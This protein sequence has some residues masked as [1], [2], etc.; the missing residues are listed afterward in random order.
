MIVRRI[1]FLLSLM[2]GAVTSQWPE[3][4]Q[5]YRQRLG[6]AVDELTRVLADF[7]RDAASA[8]MD[9]PAAI[10][11]MKQD[12]QPFYQQRGRSI[13]E[14]DARAARLS[15]QLDAFGTAGSFGRLGVLA[16][17]FDPGIAQRAYESFEPAVP[18]T[19]EGGVTAGIG[20]LIAYLL[21]RTIV[22]LPARM[23]RRRARGRVRVPA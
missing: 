16:R 6:G 10:A 3:Y 18:L 12:P 22:G 8:G 9:R 5:Q 23:R 7:D 21:L 19:V 13:A 17:D 15:H 1:V 11:H 20:F 14:T 2:I 4:A